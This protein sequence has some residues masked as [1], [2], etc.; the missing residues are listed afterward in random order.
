MDP[1]RW[2]C[3]EEIYQAAAERKPEE[4]AAFLAVACAGDEDLRREVES[5]LAQPT[6]DGMLDRPAWELDAA[7]LTVG[8]RVSHY[9]I[10]EKIGEG[11]MGV[12]YKASDTRLGRSVALKF[13]KAQFSRRWERE[14]RAVAA[15]NHPHIA[16][17][18]EVGDHQG[19][20]YLVMELVEGKPLK[21]PLPVKRAIEY[22]I[23][24]ADALGA[25]TRQASCIAT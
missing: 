7:R 19:L 22:G 1:A 17:L 3:V 25:G 10:Q 12:V 14:A 20:P 15:L 5:L 9:E 6:A 16:T 24:I 21:G 18:Y 23:Q 13:V 2:R 4:Q 11:G 8:Q